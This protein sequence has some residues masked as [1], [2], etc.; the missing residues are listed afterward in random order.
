[1]GK[2]D[3]TNALLVTASQALIIVNYRLLI[4]RLFAPLMCSPQQGEVQ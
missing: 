3:Y 4:T 2:S 1:M